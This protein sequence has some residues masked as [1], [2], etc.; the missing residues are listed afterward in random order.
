M[1]VE[2]IWYDLLWRVA[3]LDDV[4]RVIFLGALTATVMI[5]VYVVA[6]RV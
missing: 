6:M 5:G 3:Q 2:F 4:T 1:S